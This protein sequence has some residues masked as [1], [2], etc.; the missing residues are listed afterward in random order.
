MSVA[1]RRSPYKNFGITASAFNEQQSTFSIC[2]LSFFNKGYQIQAQYYGCRL[3]SE[4]KRYL[5]EES[6]S[7]MHMIVLLFPLFC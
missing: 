5:K 2:F 4:L 1:E 6:L 3:A 7:N